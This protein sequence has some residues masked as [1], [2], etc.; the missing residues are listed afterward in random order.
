M[1]FPKLDGKAVLSPMSGVTDVAFRALA[2]KYG[3]AL[4]YT[5]FVSSTSLVRGNKVAWKMTE[6]DPSEK[7]AAV[8]L[9]GSNEDD[10]VN[11]AHQL[12]DKFDITDVNCGCPAWKVIKTG[13]GSEM[14]K[15]PEKIARFINKLATAVNKPVTVKIRIGID[16]RNINA[17]QIAKLV[18][19][20]G[21]SAIAIHGRTQQQGYS[22]TANWNV[23]KQVKETVN[24]PVIGNGDVFTPEQF[25]E[26]LDYSGVDA[27][28][29]ARGAIG[30]PFIFKQIQD[31]LKTGKYEE[32]G[33]VPL[34]FEY[35]ELAQKYNLRF[36]DVKGHAI[37]FTKGIQG[38]AQVRE[39]LAK[40]TTTEEIK[41]M[42]LPKITI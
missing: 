34:F 31:Y 17:M 10:V 23:I 13:A 6:T 18:E 21:A 20:A 29:I 4:T 28:M 38:G 7:P 27:I 5:E 26:K 33:P 12:Q 39:K 24:I 2:K 36:N 1:K 9:F 35:L 30:K 32:Y 25:K 3:A 42:L 19:D 37:M 22:G 11:A 14:L 15:Q 41:E 8:Q 16:Y 40:S